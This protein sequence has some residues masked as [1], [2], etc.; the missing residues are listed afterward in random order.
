MVRSIVHLVLGTILGVGQNFGMA[1]GPQN[2]PHI[3]WFSAPVKPKQTVM[4]CGHFPQ[5]QR[6]DIVVFRLPDGKPE[7]LP[8]VEWSFP[9]T[10]GQ[11]VKLLSVTETALAFSLPDLGGDGIYGVA[12]RSGSKIVTSFRVNLPELWWALSD[13]VNR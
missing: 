4:V 1:T 12:L 11:V 10:R 6:F 8:K 9:E 13:I 7:L 5:P 3:F 2:Q